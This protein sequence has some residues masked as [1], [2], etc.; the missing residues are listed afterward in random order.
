MNQRQTLPT[1]DMS[2]PPLLL[3]PV[4][5]CGFQVLGFLALGTAILQKQSNEDDNLMMSRLII[6]RTI[7]KTNDKK[8]RNVTSLVLYKQSARKMYTSDQASNVARI[9]NPLVVN[10]LAPTSNR[11]YY[12]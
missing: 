11:K 1:V 7:T 4:E 2:L 8:Y 5:D 12:P 10:P 9:T 6:V 3:C